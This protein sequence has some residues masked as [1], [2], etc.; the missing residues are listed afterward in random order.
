MIDS[1]LLGRILKTR[2]IAGITEEQYQSLMTFRGEAMDCLDPE[3][4]PLKWE[5]DPQKYWWFPGLAWLCG[6]EWPE[7]LPH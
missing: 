5:Q 6:Q 2:S 7:H 3:A 4:Y 1:W